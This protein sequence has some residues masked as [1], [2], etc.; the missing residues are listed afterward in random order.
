MTPDPCKAH[1]KMNVPAVVCIR[2]YSKQIGLVGVVVLDV[3]W[4]VPNC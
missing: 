3:R 1:K 2:N 4:V